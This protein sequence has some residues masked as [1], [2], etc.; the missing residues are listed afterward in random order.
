MKRLQIFLAAVICL[1]SAGCAGTPFTAHDMTP[2]RD[3]IEVEGVPAFKQAENQCGP[4]ALASMLVWSGVDVTPSDLSEKV[5]DPESKGSL[6]ISLIAAARRHGRV[7]YEINGMDA[8]LSELS[9]G[10]PVLVLVNQGALWWPFYHYA[11]VCGYDPVDMQVILAAGNEHRERMRSSRF[12][13]IWNRADAW[14]LLVL[15]PQTLPATADETK[16]IEAV[17]GLELVGR[18]EEALSGYSAALEQWPHALGAMMGRANTLYALGR[19][20][21]AGETL[22]QAAAM[23]PDSGPVFNNLAHVM[24][25]MGQFDAALEAAAR[26]V[27]IGGPHMPAYLRT[28]ENVRSA[29]DAVTFEN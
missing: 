29:M 17:Y 1:L 11:V 7:A 27:D 18:H 25:E 28:F 10:N 12:Q 5:Y 19:L 15:P 22:M 4:A 20:E 6:Q 2:N 13:Q 9:A 8:L 3:V 14:G 21:S 24:L 23:H 26:A 16:W